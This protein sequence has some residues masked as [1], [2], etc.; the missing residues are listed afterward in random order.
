LVDLTQ[1]IRAPTES[2]AAS[3]ARPHVSEAQQSIVQPTEGIIAGEAVTHPVADMPQ[4]GGSGDS[5][6]LMEEKSPIPKCQPRLFK[7]VSKW[8]IAVHILR[9]YGQKREILLRGNLWN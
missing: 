6:A 1:D 5:Q 7:A 2:D 9:R 8:T 4:T 3:T